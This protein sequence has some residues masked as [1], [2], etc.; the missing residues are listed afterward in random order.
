[1]EISDIEIRRGGPTYTLDTL[2]ALPPEPQY[3]WILG[4]DQLQNF[5]TWHGWQEILSRVELAVA[6]RPGAELQAP[7]DMQAHLEKLNR[8]LHVLSM[9]PTDVSATAIRNGIAQGQSIETMLHPGVAQY[10]HQHRLYR[11]SAE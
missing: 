10:I 11:L 6:A 4:A 8:R 9:P 2:R 1:M 3:F 7:A 5:C